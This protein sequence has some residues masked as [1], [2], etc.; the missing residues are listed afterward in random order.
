MLKSQLLSDISTLATFCIRVTFFNYNPIHLN[1]QTNVSSKEAQQT[2]KT[3]HVVFLST[4]SFFIFVW[5]EH[6]SENLRIVSLCSFYLFSP[7]LS[8]AIRLNTVSLEP[9]HK[10]KTQFRF[11]VCLY[12][13][14]GKSKEDK[15]CLRGAHQLKQ[16][17]LVY[18]LKLCLRCHE[19]VCGYALEWSQLLH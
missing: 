1:L 6:E 14:V 19:L 17:I 5:V 4:V 2:D 18:H 3:K 11:E 10:N 8:V 7:F 12:I 13:Y 16:M 9:D 15:R